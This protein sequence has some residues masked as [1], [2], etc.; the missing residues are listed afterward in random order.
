MTGLRSGAVRPRRGGWLESCPD[1]RASPKLP[2]RRKIDGMPEQLV[3][4][5]GGE[6]D[7]AAATFAT[8]RPRLFGIAYRMLGSWTDA[9]DIVQDVWL[10][11]QGTDRCAVVNPAAFLATVTTR[12]CINVAQSAR[13]RRE[14]YIGPWLPEPVDTSADPTVGA[15]RGEAIELAVLLLLEKLTPTERAAYILR[16]SFAYPYPEIAAILHLS[17]ANARQLVSRARKHIAGQHRR[18]VDPAAHRR[19]LEAFLT[20]AQAGDLASLEHLLADDVISYSDGNGAPQAAKIPVIGRARVAA[21]IAGFSARFWRGTRTALVEANGRLGVLVL[22]GDTPKALL[23]VSVSDHGIQQ[24]QW[25]KNPTKLAAF[26][27]SSTRLD[28]STD[29]WSTSGSSES[30]R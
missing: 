11:W 29:T 22:T 14:R 3:A 6:L 23:T 9:E 13:A 1:R 30:C 25:M 15:E 17:P 8:V 24:I 16:E 10:R 26:A 28:L 7:E 12:L 18:P 20:A 27:R 19:L 21:F 4:Q 2:D 5:G